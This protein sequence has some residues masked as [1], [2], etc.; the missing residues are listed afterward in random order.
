MP[1]TKKK[2]RRRDI[3][4][5]RLAGYAPQK[6]A[7]QLAAMEEGLSRNRTAIRLRIVINNLIR[8]LREKYNYYKDYKENLQSTY[9]YN[10]RFNTTVSRD[11]IR[12]LYEV[13]GRIAYLIRLYDEPG[14]LEH[15]L[16]INSYDSIVDVIESTFGNM[17]ILD[18]NI[19][20][21]PQYIRDE[22]TKAELGIVNNTSRRADAITIH[23]DSVRTTALIR[24]IRS[25]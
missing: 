4:T 7:R 3:K 22:Y 11:L 16:I 18:E 5:K 1:K 13:L 6:V 25:S 19:R 8:I 14:F 17:N 15:E 24:R 9:R 21:Y 12:Q 20:L 2:N 10:Y 23:P